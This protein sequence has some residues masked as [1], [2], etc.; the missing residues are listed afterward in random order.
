VRNA[1]VAD[2]GNY[3]LSVDYSQ[4]ELRIVAHM[5][6]DQAMLDAFLAGQDIH[7]ATAAAIY[8]VPIDQVT[9]DQR[10]NAKSINFGLTYG[11]SAYGLMNYTGLTLAESED[12][13]EVYNQRFP[14]VKRFL[15]GIRRTAARQGYVETLMGRRRYFPEL[16]S[17][18]N[19]NVRNRAEREAINAPVQGTAADIMKIAMLRVPEALKEAG[20][21]AQILLQVHDELVV[22]CPQAELAEAARL[23]QKVMEEAYALK[24][25]LRTEARYGTNWGTMISLSPSQ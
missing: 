3:L 15:D 18:T 12:F 10:R 1:F 17:E 23:V 8:N 5:S 9:K 16:Q 6:D 25:P 7:A 22:E 11:M 14:G 2:P 4:V 19:I 13:V 21:S 20:L 24:A